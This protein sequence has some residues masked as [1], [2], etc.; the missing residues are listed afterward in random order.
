MIRSKV[1]AERKLRDK[2]SEIM[3]LCRYKGSPGEDK[4]ES[5]SI[6][7]VW[8]EKKSLQKLQKRKKRGGRAGSKVRREKEVVEA[9]QQR[10]EELTRKERLKHGEN[11]RLLRRKMRRLVHLST[12][13]MNG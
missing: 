8:R 11:A 9:L 12:L 3:Q 2:R 6:I 10:N 1:I 7:I 13:E 5:G 4:V